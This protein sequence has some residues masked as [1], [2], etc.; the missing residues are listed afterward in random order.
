MRVAI[1][2][3]LALGLKNIE[4]RVQ[5]LAALLRERLSAIPGVTVHD[6]GRVRSAI[7]TFKYEPHSPA[8]VMH[9]LR[10]NH[11]SVRT[12]DRSSTRIDM[13]RRGLDEMVRASLHYY[14][15]EAEI[16]NASA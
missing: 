16:A 15:T 2:Y 7:V 11:V 1:D 12:T 10:E 5:S 3:A 4:R 14:N 9:W 6:L 8:A 13:E